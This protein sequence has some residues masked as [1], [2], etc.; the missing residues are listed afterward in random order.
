MGISFFRKY[1]TYQV[2]YRK[3]GLTEEPALLQPASVAGLRVN[4]AAQ[5]CRQNAI[6]LHDAINRLQGFEQTAHLCQRH[7][8]GAIG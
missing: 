2:F 4:S 6:R 5:F 7:G 8:V 1:L 3:N